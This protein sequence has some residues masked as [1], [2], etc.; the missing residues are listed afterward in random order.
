[1]SLIKLKKDQTVFIGRH[2]NCIK[3][4]N[5]SE[6]VLSRNGVEATEL[7]E[8][9]LGV[10]DFMT[11]TKPLTSPFRKR[12]VVVTSPAIRVRQTSDILFGKAPIRIIHDDLYNFEQF[13]HVNELYQNKIEDPRE[14][15]NA[16]KEAIL[17]FQ[18]RF[19]NF[20]MSKDVMSAQYVAIMSHA[21]VSNFIAELF[22]DDSSVMDKMLPESGGF[23]ISKDGVGVITS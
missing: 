18:D 5:D 11:A 7:V 14:Y 1:M 4:E 2:G 20:L 16:D 10:L 17:S 21:I 19:K 8:N 9:S 23:L 6:R 13:P 15:Y 22:T 12:G 3:A